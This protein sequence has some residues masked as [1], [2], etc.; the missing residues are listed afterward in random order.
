[1]ILLLNLAKILLKITPPSL[2]KIFYAD[3]GSVAVEVALKMA[4]QFW[5]AQG[6]PQKQI[7]LLHVLVI[8]VIHGMRCLFVIQ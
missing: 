8:T 1:M 6:Q 3:S 2:D 7:L 4:V 5:T